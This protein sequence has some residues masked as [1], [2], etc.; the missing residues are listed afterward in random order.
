M[1][2]AGGAEMRQE[3]ESKSPP[4][5]VD[6]KGP[7]VVIEQEGKRQ[8]TG[9]SKRSSPAQRRCGISSTPSRGAIAET[10]TQS[11]AHSPAADNCQGSIGALDKA[12]LQ[13]HCGQTGH[14][15]APGV[16]A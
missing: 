15:V 4:L 5:T 7:A 10:W 6:M 12:G 14:P 3:A 9:V 16:L 8:F 2:E 13:R 1:G 11:C